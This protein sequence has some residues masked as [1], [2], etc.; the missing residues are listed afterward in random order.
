MQGALSCL[1][2]ESDNSYMA[3]KSWRGY[4]ELCEGHMVRET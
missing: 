1:S 4:L 3:I 2:N